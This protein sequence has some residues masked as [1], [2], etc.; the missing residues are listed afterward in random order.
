[1]AVQKVTF[2]DMQEPRM[3]ASKKYSELAFTENENEPQGEDFNK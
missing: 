1:M 3:I 2:N